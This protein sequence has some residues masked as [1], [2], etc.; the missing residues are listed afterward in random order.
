VRDPP[1]CAINPAPR[2]EPRSAG[3]AGGGSRAAVEGQPERPTGGDSSCTVFIRRELYLG[4]SITA[5]QPVVPSKRL[6]FF[7]MTD[8]AGLSVDESGALAHAVMARPTIRGGARR[9]RK[10]KRCLSSTAAEPPPEPEGAPPKPLVVLDW[11][12]MSSTPTKS[13]RKAESKASA[14]ERLKR[15]SL[16]VQTEFCIAGEEIG[17]QAGLQIWRV[18]SS[19]GKGTVTTCRKGESEVWSGVLR[20]SERYVFLFS[21]E[22][23]SGPS[24]LQW[25]VIAWSGADV[26]M[27]GSGVC[28]RKA[29]ELYAILCQSRPYSD[30]AQTEEP[31]GEASKLL[32]SA[33]ASN[34]DQGVELTFEKAAPPAP[35][36][37]PSGSSDP[38]SVA[39][40]SPLQALRLR[41]ASSPMLGSPPAGVGSARNQPNH[42]S[43]YSS[44][45]VMYRIHAR[46]FE[47]VLPLRSRYSTAY[48]IHTILTAPAL[49]PRRGLRLPALPLAGCDRRPCCLRCQCQQQQQQQQQ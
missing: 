24:E 43:P 26:S 15:A 19:R 2:A 32:R 16:V 39:T 25:K 47:K 36:T 22:K 42:P 37:N 30:V 48:T 34:L 44:L 14:K 18:F 20:Q 1:V 46:W 7:A 6:V 4:P 40:A 38:S 3:W 49:Q 29:K 23:G 21:H 13:P 17:T 28:T 5:R 27:L 8:E 41:R 10:T 12:S 33:F 9:H 11:A 35:P 31:L 45:P